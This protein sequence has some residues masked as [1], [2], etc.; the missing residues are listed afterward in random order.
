VR[1][2]KQTNESAKRVAGCAR[3]H[4]STSCA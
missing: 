1:R 3:D 4:V 2:I